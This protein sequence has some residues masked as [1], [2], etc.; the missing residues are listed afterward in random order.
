MN[1]L[2]TLVLLAIIG[3]LLPFAFRLTLEL[4]EAGG[5]R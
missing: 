1:L 4:Y 2:T 5:R 3:A